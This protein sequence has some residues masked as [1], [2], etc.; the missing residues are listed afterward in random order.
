MWMRLGYVPSV[1]HPRT[2]NEKIAHRKLFTREPIYTLLA[3]KWAVRDYVKQKIGGE[4]L[5]QVY[6]HVT[7]VSD[8]DIASLPDSFVAKGRHNWGST[9]I[10]DDKNKQSWDVLRERFRSSLRKGFNPTLNEY[11]YASIPRGLIIEERLRDDRYFVPLDFKF[12]VFHGTA[13]FIQVFHNRQ[14]RIAQRTY[15]RTWKPLL[16]RRP[17]E[18]I[19]PVIKRPKQLDLMIE[20]AEALAEGFDFVRVDLYAPNDD[21][22]VFG[23]YTFAPASGRRAFVPRSFDWELGRLW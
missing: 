14:A 20:V 6:Q 9:I 3:D 17:G 11:W 1:R 8:L 5:T 7:D 23:E 12:L 18:P 2:F 21:R 22:I 10:V 4:F 19:A 13:K 16:V 15:D